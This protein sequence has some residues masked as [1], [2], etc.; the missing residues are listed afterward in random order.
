MAWKNRITGH[1]GP[2]I[3]GGANF[4]L[5][6]AAVVAIVVLANWFVDRH[7]RRW[8]LTPDQKYSLS[9]QTTKL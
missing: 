3:L 6:T 4:V 9:P 7:N 5:Y 8:D 2:R 1:F